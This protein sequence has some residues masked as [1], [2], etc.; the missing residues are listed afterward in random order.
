M[1]KASNARIFY[2]NYKD[3]DPLD[4]IAGIFSKNAL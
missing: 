3:I 1:D 2:L 4:E